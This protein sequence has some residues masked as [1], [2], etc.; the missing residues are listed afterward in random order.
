MGELIFEA[1]DYGKP[2]SAAWA[3]RARSLWPSTVRTWAFA[4]FQPGRRSVTTG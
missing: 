3:A 1:A 2:G 4:A